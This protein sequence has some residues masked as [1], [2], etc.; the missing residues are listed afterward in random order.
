VPNGREEFGRQLTELGIESSIGPAEGQLT[1]QYRVPGGRFHGQQITIGLVV[2]P[3]FPRNPPGGPHVRPALLPMNPNAADH[4]HRAAPSPLGAEWQ[5]LSRPFR[6]RWT[7]RQ[8]AAE[9]LAHIDH[10]FVTT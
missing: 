6:G 10:L 5:Y 3:D 4:P 8:G 9:Y 7:G 1:F 2:P